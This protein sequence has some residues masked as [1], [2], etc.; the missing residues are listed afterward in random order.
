MR[1]DPLLSSSLAPSLGAC[2]KSRASLSEVSYSSTNADA[3]HPKVYAGEP[4]KSVEPLSKGLPVS[5][6]MESCDCLA[7]CDN[8]KLL[9]MRKLKLHG[10]MEG[11]CYG[12]SFVQV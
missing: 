2:R 4:A 3:V 6:L 8:M 5:V 7:G 1:N 11:F 10:Q 12:T 9:A